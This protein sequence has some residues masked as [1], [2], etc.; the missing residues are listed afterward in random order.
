MKIAVVGAGT[1]GLLS[2]VTLCQSLPPFIE[3][4]LIHSNDIAPIGV[5]ESTLLDFPEIL[6]EGID[7]YHLLDKKEMNATTKFGVRFVGWQDD[8]FYITFGSG[9]HG[10]HFDSAALSQFVIP[11]L[12]KKYGRFM[13]VRAT[14]KELNEVG[15]KV[16]VECDNDVFEFDYVV[17]C[18]G[19]PEDYKN[20]IEPKNVYLNSAITVA[21]EGI[22]DWQYTAHIAH[23]HGWMFAVPLNDRT[24]LGYLYNDNFCERHD[25]LYEMDKIAKRLNLQVDFDEAKEF[26]FKN[27]YAKKVVS[28]TSRIFLNGNR[29]LF[30]EP[31]QATSIGCYSMINKLIVDYINHDIEIDKLQEDYEKMIKEALMFI[32]IHYSKGS[33]YDSPFWKM[34]QDA[35]KKCINEYDVYNY[36]WEYLIDSLPLTNQ[37][38]DRFLHGREKALV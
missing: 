27:Y 33:V 8:D 19:F 22:V 31:I 1:A 21:S 34:S 25:A 30:F 16:F 12:Q 7:Y 13:E 20:Y 14:V 5:G 10:L 29:A 37:M 38:R 28:S 11:R 36:K 9:C 6:C 18:R 4:Y 15:D 23:E 26:K 32:N 2:A 24:G 3:V 35:S 17:D